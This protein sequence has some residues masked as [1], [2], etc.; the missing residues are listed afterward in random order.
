GLPSEIPGR[1]LRLPGQCP[2]SS[3][4]VPQVLGVLGFAGLDLERCLV[5]RSL[6]GGAREAMLN[7]GA[8][9]FEELVH[10]QGCFRPAAPGAREEPLERLHLLAGLLK[11]VDDRVYSVTEQGR[12]RKRGVQEKDLV[13]LPDIRQGQP[14]A[15]NAA[16]WWHGE[17]NQRPNAALERRLHSLPPFHPALSAGP[18]V[19]LQHGVKA[20]TSLTHCCV[21]FAQQSRG[22]TQEGSAG[23]LRDDASS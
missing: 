21:P 18:L 11:P 19:C 13:M 15:T 7:F 14:H 8:F 16:L 22:G 12:R 5:L 3:Q 23:A 4:N 20:R 2:L 1:S 9:R 17:T 6:R 10:G